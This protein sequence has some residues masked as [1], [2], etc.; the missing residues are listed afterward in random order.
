ML[1]NIKILSVLLA[2]IFLFSCSKGTTDDDL[3]Q[4]KTIFETISTSMGYSYLSYALQK[5]ELDVV[6]SGAGPYTLFAPDNDAFILFLMEN[7]YSSV[8]EVPTDLLRQLLLNHVMAGQKEYRNFVTG[9]FQTQA[10]SAVND[11]PLSLYINQV[12]MRVRLNGTARIVQGNVR[13]TN[14]II[15]AVDNIIPIPTLVTFVVSDP[16]LYNLALALTR[17]DLTVDYIEI[18]SAENDNI[19]APFTVFAPTNQAFVNVLSELELSYLIDIDEPTLKA[20]LD[21]HV[22]VDSSV[23]YA[24]LTD[25]LTLSTLG[26]EL[27]ANLSDGASLTDGNARTANITLPDIQA[28]N[29]VMHFIDKVILPY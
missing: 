3:P 9:Y 21:H 5:T 18:L 25:N 16:A 11:L 17:S 8:E 2:S 6:L 13:A 27:T 24:D 15:H 22:L 28:N 29:G 4:D 26:G 7:G 12:S 14:G 20:T 1:K 10:N 19:H 23:L